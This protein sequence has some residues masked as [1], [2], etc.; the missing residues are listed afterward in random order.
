MF[1][2]SNRL[3]LPPETVSRTIGIIAQRGAGKTYTAMLITEQMLTHGHQVVCLDPTGVWHGLRTSA[4]GKSDG[5]PILVMG[6][7]NGDVPLE[8]TAG[9]IVARFV[10]ETG[11][12][13]ILDL[14]AFPSQRAQDRFATDFAE[15]IYRRKSTNRRPV[16]LM[17]D[18]ADAFAPQKPQK[19]QERMLGAFDTIV[20]RGRAYGLGI[21]L[22]SQRPA[23]L[24]KN[25]LSQVDIL[26]TG[27]IT[28]SHDHKALTTWTDMYGTADEKRDYLTTVPKLPVG[29]MWLWSPGWLERFTRITINKRETYDSSSTPTGTTAAPKVARAKVDLGK[30]SQDIRDSVERAAENDPQKLRARIQVLQRELDAERL[31]KAAPA[32]PEIKEVP[33]L[34][35]A[36]LAALDKLREDIVAAGG[37]VLEMLAPMRKELEAII[38]PAA[39]LAH[40]AP[41]KQQYP[42]AG[43]GDNVLQLEKGKAANRKPLIS[44]V[45][46]TPEMLDGSFSTKGNEPLTKCERAILTVLAQ[47]AN[48]CT[49]RKV[50][51]IS[52]Y[53]VTSGSFRNSL[54]TL[55]TAGRV[56]VDGD[57][58]AITA[59]GR[60]DLG[61]FE[62]LPEGAAAIRHWIGKLTKCESA[63]L[64]VLLDN[65]PTTK[66]AIAEKTDPPYAVTS[67]S[68]RNSLSSL[69]TRELISRTEPITLLY[70]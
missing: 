34:T 29:E 19:G 70:A 26:L 23:V 10:V 16:H 35:P 24:N 5:L 53:S 62:P 32:K 4:D 38:T 61:S 64:Q 21:T 42:N 14:S 56:S 44:S 8:E 3:S 20:R 33:I 13:V 28:G 69:R 1:R 49:K 54:S 25:V 22:I 2:I 30:L 48:E 39:A 18:E 63:I 55:R 9:A 57:F 51:L 52:N 7:T 11:S 47:N 67:G 6:G 37:K 65:G 41:R 40:E 43:P 31:K 68:F 50:A 27:R 60:E 59:A 46:M 58:V 17:I 66:E 12:S 15:A 45:P 36:N